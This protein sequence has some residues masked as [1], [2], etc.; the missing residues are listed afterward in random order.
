MEASYCWQSFFFTPITEI[1]KLKLPKSRVQLSVSP[2]EWPGN[3]W[4][5]ERVG[6]GAAL[7]EAKIKRS[8]RVDQ[9]QSPVLCFKM[10][11]AT[12]T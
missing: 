3:V 12:R 5:Q 7:H 10:I 4:Q 9:E 1:K 6:G 2:G 11:G 8:I